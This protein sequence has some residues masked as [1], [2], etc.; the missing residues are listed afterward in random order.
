MMRSRSLG[1][2]AA[3]VALVVLSAC[4]AVPDD[5]LAREL[6][7]E[8]N[9][10]LEPLNRA[11]FAFNTEMDRVLLEPAVRAYRATVPQPGRSAITRLLTN[12]LLPLTFVNNLLQFEFER[13][14]E[15]AAAFL[16]NSTVGIGGLFNVV[17]Y[18]IH[19]EDFGQTLAVWSAGEGPYL[20]LPLYGPSNVRDGIGLMGDAMLDPWGPAFDD[21]TDLGRFRTARAL[22][23]AVSAREALLEDSAELRRSSVDFYAAARSLYRQNRGNEVRNG[24]PGPDPV[25]QWSD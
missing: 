9:D 21:P 3:A 25:F 24:G 19:N 12:L 20:V 14:A 13:A 18:E 10:P 17:E 2:A 1:R 6:Y 23:T 15:T 8:D 7:Y 16:V 4:A 11:V 5:P 22:A